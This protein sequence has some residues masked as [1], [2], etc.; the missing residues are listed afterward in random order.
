MPIESFFINPP[1]F[2]LAERRADHL[3]EYQSDVHGH[4]TW[5]ASTD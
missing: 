3:R 4:M 1:E 5:R 2:A